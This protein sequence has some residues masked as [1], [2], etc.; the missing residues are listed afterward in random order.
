MESKIENN[1]Q[2]NN[3]GKMEGMMPMQPVPEDVFPD[4]EMNDVN[5]A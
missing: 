3:G 5:D 2:P 1:D 4:Q